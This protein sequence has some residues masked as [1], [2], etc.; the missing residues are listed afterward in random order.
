MAIKKGDFMKTSIRMMLVMAL[1]VL[2]AACGSPL[3][4]DENDNEISKGEDM[5]A[6]ATGLTPK[7]WSFLI[8]MD[9][10]N[11][12]DGW[13]Q[14]N[15]NQILKTLTSDQDVNV[16]ALDDH[17]G[18]PAKLLQITSNGVVTLPCYPAL[19]AVNSEP[20][21]GNAKTLEDFLSWAVTNFPANHYVVV[22]WD[23]GGGWKSIAVDNTSGSRM[24]IDALGHA[25]DAVALQIGR[26]LDI[27][28]FDA[29]V[30]SMIEVAD[31]LKNAS[32]FMV[33]SESTV[34]SSGFPYHLMIQRLVANPGQLPWN[35]AKGIVDD[36][37]AYYTK[38]QADAAALDLDPNKIEPLVNAI[39]SLAIELI[40]NMPA[41][42]NDIGS[43]RSV[44][45]NTVGGTNGV[46]WFDDIKLF[47]DV[48]ASRIGNEILDETSA[49]NTALANALY[50][51][52]TSNLNGKQYGL[53]IN[54]P[55]NETKY[56]D[57]S[58]LAQ[59]YAGIGL[60]FPLETHWD[61]MLLA[62][63]EY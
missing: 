54:F 29:C 4:I 47:V 14:F 24:M 16:V 45:K 51:R 28:L 58:Y 1:V 30:M 59:N 21:M 56:Y 39:D 12:L 2:F 23:H 20:D 17:Y 35:F 5:P 50:E 9:E 6:F 25:M 7:E 46:F 36:H 60:V 15:I 55:A 3:D 43:A 53:S 37:V 11:S 44:A 41:W 31:Q 8:Y 34:G 26:K 40:N 18:A 19:C 61:E 42:H 32:D 38:K 63:Y 52:H 13:G 33:A 62:Y 10:D 48:L 27:T 49:V 22:V 57:K